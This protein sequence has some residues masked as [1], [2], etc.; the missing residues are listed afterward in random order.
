MK[1]VILI[2]IVLAV[3]GW[4]LFRPERIFIDTTVNESLPDAGENAATADS[5][6][7][8]LSSGIFHGVAHDAKG[9]AEIIELSDGKKFLRFTDFAVW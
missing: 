8:I 6:P 4:Y 2:L 7:K 5:G 9:N 3:F 1:Y